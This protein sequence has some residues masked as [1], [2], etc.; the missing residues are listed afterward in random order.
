[1]NQAT[2][3]HLDCTASEDVRH[4][5]AFF[6]GE[7]E[8]YR[9]LLPFIAEGFTRGEKAVHIITPDQES[10]HLARLAEAGI[11]LPAARERGQLDVRRNDDVYLSGGRFDQDRMV[12]AF[13]AMAGGDGT[14]PISRIVCNMDWAGQSPHHEELIEFEARVNE[15]WRRH[16]DIVICVYDLK[17]LSGDMLIDIL[18]THPMVL[19]GDAVQQNPFFIE[20][21]AFLRA[22]RGEIAGTGR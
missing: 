13:E 11:D 14:F 6:N 2:G 8:A 18:R 19:I 21:G 7:D 5:C 12:A 16:R 17:M 1:M 15:I 9:T 10:R 20:P 3:M 4:A 22:R